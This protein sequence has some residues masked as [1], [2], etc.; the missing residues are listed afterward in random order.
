M[1][2]E[3]VRKRKRMLMECKDVL[4][5]FRQVYGLR[6]ARADGTR[7][8][9]NRRRLLSSVSLLGRSVPTTVLSATVGSCTR[10]KPAKAFVLCGLLF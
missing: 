5:G 3:S 1:E 9:K 10:V 8:N 4:I 6:H 2:E 7:L